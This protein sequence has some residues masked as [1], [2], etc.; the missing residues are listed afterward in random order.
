[1]KYNHFNKLFDKSLLI[2]QIC[3]KTSV[4]FSDPS[5]FNNIKGARKSFFFMLNIPIAYRSI[6]LY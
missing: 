3:I 4:S 1:M 5:H 2:S 6:F